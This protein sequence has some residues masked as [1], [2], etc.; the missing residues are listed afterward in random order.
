MRKNFTRKNSIKKCGSKKFLTIK[1]QSGFSFMP[2]LKTD[3]PLQVQIIS[4]VCRINVHIHTRQ[5]NRNKRANNQAANN[6]IYES[7]SFN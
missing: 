3:W 1:P 2:I 4:S 6:R 5:Q 7:K